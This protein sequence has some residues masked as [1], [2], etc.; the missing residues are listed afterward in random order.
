MNN[1]VTDKSPYQSHFG[2]YIFLDLVALGRAVPC[3]NSEMFSES[4]AYA[5]LT[6]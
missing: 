4:Y 5:I 1:A 6:L 2:P 3:I